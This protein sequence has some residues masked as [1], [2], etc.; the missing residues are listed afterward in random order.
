LLLLLLIEVIGTE[1]GILAT[2]TALRWHV[3]GIEL[4]VEE[5]ETRHMGG[6]VE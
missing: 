6:C 4:A 2:M 1:I 3:G 5:D